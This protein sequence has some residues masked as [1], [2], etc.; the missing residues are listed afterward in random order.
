MVVTRS[1]AAVPPCMPRHTRAPCARLTPRSAAG[2]TPQ[3]QGSEP[4]QGDVR[5]VPLQGTGPT[6][7]C[8]AVHA[9]V[10][11]IFNDGVWGRICQLPSQD[12]RDST[13][14]LIPQA[15]PSHMQCICNTCCTCMYSMRVV[16][17]CNLRQRAAPAS[18]TLSPGIAATLAHL[19]G[20]ELRR[21]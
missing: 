19:K 18:Y 4:A 14:T 2:C 15:R 21:D 7:V 12:F 17:G 5:L 11:E 20:T 10:I 3:G 6:S 9:G 1:D 13:Y 16:S 8:D